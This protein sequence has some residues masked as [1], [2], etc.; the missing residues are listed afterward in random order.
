MSPVLTLQPLHH[1]YAKYKVAVVGF[2]DLSLKV[3]QSQSLSLRFNYF[4]AQLG[5]KLNYDDI[6]GQQVWVNRI[7]VFEHGLIFKKSF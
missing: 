3:N 7:G 4:Y 1:G 6:R 2:C 5:T